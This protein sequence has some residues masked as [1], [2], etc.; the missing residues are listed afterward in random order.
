[1]IELDKKNI[2][3]LD[4]DYKFNIEKIS[5]IHNNISFNTNIDKDNSTEIYQYSL[6]R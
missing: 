5:A 1:M 4:N 3:Q 6:Q 2:Y